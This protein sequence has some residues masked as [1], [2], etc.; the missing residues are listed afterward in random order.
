M[1]PGDVATLHCPAC[2]KSFQA[3]NYKPGGAYKCP[4][5]KGP[6]ERQDLSAV[7]TVAKD[8]LSFQDEPPPIP[9]EIPVRLGKYLIDGEIARGGMGV[10]YKG[11][12]EG[13]DRVVAIKMLLGGVHADP[14]ALHRF[15]REARS[16]AKLRHP[17]I[18]AIHEVGD[19]QGQPFFTMDYIEGKS[20]DQ[21]LRQEGMFQLERGVRLLRDV[22][23]AV[24]FAHE[25]GIIHRDL[26][27]GNVLLDKDDAPHVTDF[28][29]AKELDSKSMISV[30]GEVMGTPS[31]M[32][33]EQAE[34]RVREL[35]RRTDVYSL[36]AILYR[37]LTGKP[38]FE[39]PTMAATVY[40]VVHEYTTEPV[41]L[42]PDVGAELSAVC[43]K[44]LEKDREARYATAD[45]FAR[46][47]DRYLKGEPVSAKPLSTAQRIRRAA[48]RQRRLVVATGSV[49]AVALAAIVAILLFVR[50]GEL[51]LIEEN[52][53]NPELRMTA[54]QALLG[55]L[56]RF[57]DRKRALALAREAVRKS[58]DD[59]SRKLAYAKPAKDLADAYLE[60]V[61]IEKPEDLR[62]QVVWILSQL[63]HRA[64]VP[65]MLDLLRTARG[66]VRLAAVKFFKSVPDVRAYYSL[67]ALITDKECGE[68]ARMALQRQYVDRIVGFINPAAGKTTGVVADLGE[69]IQKYNQQVEGVLG[70]T[71]R[72]SGPKDA[73]EA[74]LL[75]LRNPDPPQRM[76]AAYE[77]GESGD[78]RARDPLVAAL[79]DADDG[80]ARM[81]AAA[82]NRLGAGTV[83]EKLVPMLRD[84]RA[85]V[86]RNA[87]WLL[88]KAGDKSLRAAVEAAYKTESDQEAKYAME[89]ALVALR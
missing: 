84:A 46:D 11:R 34:G 24:H 89:D 14:D 16:A 77:L 15:Q 61:S 75:E 23:R 18:V 42:N 31:F 70:E 38:P 85:V 65:V 53:K 64:A 86:R 44:A 51:D 40:K 87:A 32:S 52:L 12:Q 28:G 8:D 50:K 47:L 74:A 17:H 25:N 45:A 13:L 79:S 9:R 29:L 57:D 54:F 67:G 60:H 37:L 3:K 4:S 49:A 43:M 82:L 7:A 41:K 71:S 88:G 63:Q 35:D 76:K 22:A 81:A 2:L 80:V 1:P 36:G 39:G 21:A 68:E 30:T 20:L 27:P 55:G 33:P 72:P 83:R 59:A 56:D 10:V 62:V 78:A 5:C 6:L 73:V 48:G 58:T 19:F 66:P 26:K 69:A